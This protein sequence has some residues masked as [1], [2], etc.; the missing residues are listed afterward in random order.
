MYITGSVG[1][2]HGLFSHHHRHYIVML[3]E[4]QAG[5]LL[6]GTRPNNGHICYLFL[7]NITVSTTITSITM[8]TIML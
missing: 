2:G 8:C 4:L 6:P 3:R 5:K 7:S 1:L